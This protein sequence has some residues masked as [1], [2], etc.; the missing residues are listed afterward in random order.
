MDPWLRSPICMETETA[1]SEHHLHNTN[2][3]ERDWW[4]LLLI[5]QK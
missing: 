3:S 4:R 5:L 2:D 1:E